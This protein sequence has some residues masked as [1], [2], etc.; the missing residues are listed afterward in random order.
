MRP[1]ILAFIYAM[2]MINAYLCL[3]YRR[4]DRRVSLFRC[5]VSFLLIVV[6]ES[7][8]VLGFALQSMPTSPWGRDALA[9][10]AHHRVQAWLCRGQS[11]SFLQ[12]AAKYAADGSEPDRAL[13]RYWRE[14]AETEAR[15]AEFHER[16][17]RKYQ[18]AARYPWFPVDP[19]PPAPKPPN[20]KGGA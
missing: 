15:L 14:E 6:A 4:R 20:G 19:D 5:R 3:L 7:A 2:V 12:T 17:A 8:V 13:N 16:L 1:E 10:S 18:Y 9:K 11:Q